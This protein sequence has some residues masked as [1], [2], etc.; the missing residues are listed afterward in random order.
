MT[1]INR[2]ESLW[3]KILAHLNIWTFEMLL[4]NGYK[5]CCLTKEIEYYIAIKKTNHL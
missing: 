3:N 1:M 5:F 2:F 4:N